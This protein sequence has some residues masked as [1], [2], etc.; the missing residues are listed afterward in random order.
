M[1][2]GSVAPSPW[3]PDQSHQTLTSPAPCHLPQS[4]VSA[5]IQ[6]SFP[7][8]H[9]QRIIWGNAGFARPRSHQGTG[10]YKKELIQIYENLRSKVLALLPHLKDD[11]ILYFSLVGMWLQRAEDVALEGKPSK[12]SDRFFLLLQVQ[13]DCQPAPYS[14]PTALLNWA[15]PSCEPSGNFVTWSTF[16]EPMNPT[17]LICWVLC[18]N[19]GRIFFFFPKQRKKETLH[20]S[21]YQMLYQ[22]NI[23]QFCFVF[24]FE[25][26]RN[27]MWF[28]NICISLEH[29]VVRSWLKVSITHQTFLQRSCTKF[30]HYSTNASLKQYQTELEMC[31]PISITATPS[32]IHS[33]YQ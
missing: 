31:Q 12:V 28:E 9:C 29:I 3:L 18:I 23:T 19:L 1:T 11:T 15:S 2:G 20:P 22:I 25:R 16:S 13:R 17:A 5:I 30:P 8:E 7:W 10:L 14:T 32:W 6:Y 24:F 4:A 33:R 27:I 26:E 21:S